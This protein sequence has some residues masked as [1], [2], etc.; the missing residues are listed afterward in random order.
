ME[1]I[2]LIVIFIFISFGGYC[3]PFGVGF[4]I[5]STTDSSR[6]Y[7]PDTNLSD[8]LHCRPVEI[9]VWYPAEIV[10]AD[11]VALFVDFV[12]LL[13]Q[14]GN[15][16]GDTNNYSGLTEEML[17][18]IGSGIG[19]SDDQ[20]KNLPTESYLGAMPAKGTF[21]L[22]LYL[23]GW[24]GMGYEN[25][26]LFEDLARRGFVVASVSSI[27]RYPGNMTM[28]IDDLMEQVDDAIFI[29]RVISDQMAIADK[30]GLAGY[31]WGGLA[32]AIVAMKKPDKVKAIVS[33]DGSEQMRYT[34]SEAVGK[35]SH[36]RSAGFFNPKAIKGSF[37]AL[38][39]DFAED[40]ALPDSVYHFV[41]DLPDGKVYL[42]IN[43]SSHDDFS[44][45]STLLLTEEQM[46]KSQCRTIRQ[47]TVDF[48]SDKFYGSTTFNPQVVA[49][50]V[51]TQFL[52]PVHHLSPQ[53]KGIL[54]KGVVCDSR[55]N[56]P[57]RYVNIGIIN[58]D[59]GTT[60]NAKGEFMFSVSD[61]N[62]SDT[63]RVSM[64]G[65]EPQQFL[66]KDIVGLPTRVFD[67][68]LHEQPDRLGEIVITGKRLQPKT[69]GNNAHSKF[70][71]GKFAP[72]DWG[73][74]IAI[75]VNIRN[76]PTYLTKFGFHVSY[77]AGDTATF[78]V[79]IY[80]VNNGLPGDNILPENVIVKINGETGYIETDLSK[81]HLA[82]DDDIFIALEWIDGKRNSGIVFSAGLMNNGTYYRK[83][84]Q[85]RWK[86]HAMGIGLY[87]VTKY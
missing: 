11:T 60:T 10:P 64:V 76:N 71:G 47:L 52:E 65:F 31:S 25:Y 38:D 81:Y 85:G 79:N 15:I 5:I 70:F 51:S 74:E 23:A 12:H 33:L 36:I 49:G 72:G 73:S 55:F 34:D 50:K 35:L 22:I 39:S 9:D 46:A 63:L 18:Y 62:V 40:E 69:L 67:I 16:Y 48:L 14:R 30:I 6:I 3:Q 66:L 83:A 57:L 61:M 82:V 75:R 45:L 32:A 42:R 13:E 56:L 77:N 68:K 41:D 24:N 20:L 27:G 7:K 1:K 19:C 54:L 86:K 4:K 17:Q 59:E 78:R 8:K 84:S 53:K 80:R 87:I 28:D 43:G 26:Q 2:K 21:P 44:G 58:R 37:L 29:S